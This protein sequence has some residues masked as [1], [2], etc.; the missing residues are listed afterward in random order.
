M[1]ESYPAV[2]GPGPHSDNHPS[3]WSPLPPQSLA[4]PALSHWQHQPTHS[5]RQPPPPPPQFA[6]EQRGMYFHHGAPQDQGYRQL[7]PGGSRAAPDPPS[8]LYTGSDPRQYSLP[9]SGPRDPSNSVSHPAWNAPWDGKSLP[10]G[11]HGQSDPGVTR[12]AHSGREGILAE[13]VEPPPPHWVSSSQQ[14][15]QGRPPGPTESYTGLGA[16][17]HNQSQQ[18]PQWAPNYM[19]ASLESR[20]YQSDPFQSPLYQGSSETPATYDGN[21]PSRGERSQPNFQPDPYQS[22]F[23][24]GPSEVRTGYD[25][26]Q[27]SRGERS[28]PNFQPDPYQSPF[29]QGP[30]E[31]RTGYDG[32]PL[33]RDQSQPFISPYPY[34]STVHRGTSAIDGAMGGAGAAPRDAGQ[35]FA[36]LRIPN[37]VPNNSEPVGYRPPSGPPTSNGYQP[38]QPR[39]SAAGPSQYQTYQTQL[40][41]SLE[42]SIGHSGTSGHAAGNNTA[43]GL[44][45]QN[46]GALDQRLAQG[47]ATLANTS[48]STLQRGGHERNPAFSLPGTA[49]PRVREALYSYQQEL[50]EQ[51]KD[52]NTI[53]FCPTGSGKTIVALAVTE[54]VLL[55]RPPRPKREGIA[56][57]HMVVFLSDRM[58]LLEQQHSYFC[59]YSTHV[60]SEFVHADHNPGDWATLYSRCNVVFMIASIFLDLLK[61]GVVLITDLDLLIFDECHH[62]TR[63]HPFNNIFQFFFD[64]AES[65]ARPQV[66][67]MTASP[68]GDVD[69][70]VT[71]MR[72]RELCQNMSSKIIIVQQHIAELELRAPTAKT[73]Q[74][75]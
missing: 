25:G 38:S 67:G 20:A 2:S 7:P 10:P 73:I 50:Y 11:G 43:A 52:E 39:G 74:V 45:D 15:Q 66:L 16:E 41:A 1:M 6:D 42:K 3:S 34:Q 14:Q 40:P 8:G 28:Q 21:Q 68:G 55:D 54:H 57:K 33:P 58:A 65:D 29:Y 37:E 49:Y 69:H 32:R 51:A 46:P 30:S 18:P 27:P 47:P 44:C 72:I 75:A 4:Q 63:K 31:V 48:V 23:Y 70:T 62:C 17:H 13:P 22:P 35:P 60:K 53:I 26:N 12:V 36:P 19:P 5:Q 59:E 56:A 9:P 71:A 64:R 61:T 24:Q